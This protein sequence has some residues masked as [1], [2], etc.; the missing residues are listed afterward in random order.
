MTPTVSFKHTC[1]LDS[2][3][4]ESENSF[5]FRYP[6]GNYM[7][8]VNN[9]NTRRRCEICSKLTIK[10]SER[11]QSRCSGVFIVN[12]KHISHLVLVFLL[13]IDFHMKISCRFEISFRS[14]LSIWNSCRF[15]FHFAS[16]HVNTSKELTKHQSAIFNQN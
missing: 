7:F 15:E 3:S 13:L 6:A 11:R 8:K 9:R 1:A 5:W 12:F 4:N 2:K 16:I 10:V 14:K